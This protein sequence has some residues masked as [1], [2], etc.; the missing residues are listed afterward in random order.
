MTRRRLVV[1]SLAGAGLLAGALVAALA[2]TTGG[3]SKEAAAGPVGVSRIATMLAGIPQH[4]E[5]LGSS[6]APVTMIEFADPQCPYC[7]A[8][9]RSALPTIVQRYVRSGKVRILFNGMA[10]VGADS[11][12]ALRTALAA[13]RQ[14]R[15]WNVIELLF[16]NQ[17][18]E[19]TGWVTD[20]LLRSIGDAV[21]GLDA[22]KMLD[23]RGSAAVDQA[24]ARAE[25]LAQEAGVNSTPT[26]AVGKTGG[27]LQ[28][29]TVTSLD[30]S[31]LTP[32]LDAA[33]A[34]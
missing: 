27:T 31:G 16:E 9:A 24:V 34:G 11:L 33:L 18:T 22:Q 15:F 14:D 21:P 6:K 10:F 19:N 26:F 17:G 20:S 1:L 28:I 12:T 3:S 30:P 4:A 7:A 32:S 23:E 5:A 8:W 25:A 2:L 13:G 29:V